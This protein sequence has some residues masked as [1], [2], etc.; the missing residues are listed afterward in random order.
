MNS[1]RTFTIIGV[2]FGLIGVVVLGVGTALAVSTARFQASAERTE[3]TVVALSERTSTSSG[4]G[5]STSWYPTVEYTVDGRPY[6]FDSPVGANPPAYAE[7]DTV[8][9]AYDPAD[10]SDAQIASFW[11]AYFAPMVLGGLG[12]VFTPIGV[13]LLV[14]GRRSLLRR[15]KLLQDGREVWAEIAQVGVEFGVKINGRHP[16]VVH[17]TWYDERTGRTHIATSDHLRA[18]PG[19]GLLG[20]THVRVLYDP[21][22]P[23]RNVV[24]L[25]SVR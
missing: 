12:I 4:G 1:G 5:S 19:P 9:V 17:A 18:D 21:A 6:S 15:R 23:D 14:V 8:P 25:D 10:P 16:Y 2:V 20:R 24:D 22:D 13:A 7:G 11:S 3:G